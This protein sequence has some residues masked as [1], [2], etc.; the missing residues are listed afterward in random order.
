MY[1][2]FYKKGYLV[3]MTANDRFDLN[4]EVDKAND[5]MNRYLPE[6]IEVEQE[7]NFGDQ[8]HDL[9]ALLSTRPEL[10]D[11]KCVSLED[12]CKLVR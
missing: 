1:A 5:Y 9:K 10:Q 12:F 8:V 11:Y 6:W 3:F 4:S 7:L 2:I